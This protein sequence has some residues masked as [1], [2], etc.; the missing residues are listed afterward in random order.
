MTPLEHLSGIFSISLCFWGIFGLYTNF[1]IRL[2]IIKRYEQ[3]TSL[4]RTKYFNECM[5]WAKYT[6]P[7]F[8]SVLYASHLLTFVPGRGKNKSTKLMNK[9]KK[10]KLYDDIENLEQVTRH[11]SDKEIRRAKL[12]VKC[13]II[14]AIHAVAYLA[15]QF[16]WPETFS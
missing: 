16:I 12:F 4:G 2:F 15:F 3:E 13:G 8:K 9:L 11:F 5:P 1:R 6:P 7:F 14:I 10:N